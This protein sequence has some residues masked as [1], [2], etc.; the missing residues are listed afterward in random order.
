[1][2]LLHGIATAPASLWGVDW[3]LR[4]K[5]YRVL[6]LHYPSRHL[7][8]AD[9]VDRLHERGGA[10][11]HGGNGPLHIVAHSMGGL[12]ARA[13][14]AQRRPPGL[15]RVVML[16]TPNG[17]SELADR[18][19]R[20]RP[21][22]WLFGPAGQQLGTRRDDALVQLLGTVDYPVGVIA[23]SRTWDPLGLLVLPRPHDG[24]VPVARTTLDGM[25][26]H[27]TVPVGHMMLPWHPRPLRQTLHFLRHGRFKRP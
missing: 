13:Y 19:L 1:M 8:L 17:G 20:F 18:L 7:P 21:Y 14:L 26:D 11:M 15:G 22:R 3:Y 12:L 9:L 25:A 4:A 5:G 27:I 10:F 2:L 6:N 23:G 24:K 16:G